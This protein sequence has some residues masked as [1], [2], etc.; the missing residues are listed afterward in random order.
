[1]TQGK[2]C[3]LILDPILASNF[4]YNMNCL[5]MDA[6]WVMY[7]TMGGIKV[8]EANFSKLIQTRSQIIATTL[9]NRS[10]DYKTRLCRMFA[11]EII[12]K[13]ERNAITPVV[14]LVLPLSQVAKAHSHVESNA[15]IGKV[16]LL[17]D[18]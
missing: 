8:P 11:E 7:G 3:N 10:D 1:M 2:G 5:A 4:D 13:F 18:L 9:R 16:V 17:N 15:N 12:P 14:D 6:R